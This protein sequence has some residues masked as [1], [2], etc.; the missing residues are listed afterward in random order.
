M[1]E[2]IYPCMLCDIIL[3]LMNERALIMG[4]HTSDELVH[5]FY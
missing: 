2:H 3:N 5:L 4:I 1:Y